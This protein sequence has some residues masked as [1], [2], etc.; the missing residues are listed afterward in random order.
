M[1][2]LMLGW[3]LPPHNSGGL[4]VACLNLA[5]A[6]SRQGVD[7]DFV[8]P[9][10]ADHPGIDFMRVLAATKLS[11]IY[12][13]GGGAYESLKL[14]EKIIPAEAQSDQKIS[15]REVQKDYCHFV[16]EYLM[17]FKPD[18]V[19]AHDWLT[20][21]AGMLARKNFGIP[22]P[23]HRIRSRWHAPWQPSDS[24]NRATGPPDGRQNHRRF[25]SD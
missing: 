21:E 17:E 6:L 1:K 19:H 15:I 2:I 23:R 5:R 7:I 16:E 11:P 12:R 8:V 18:L 25:R 3:E 4:G 9:Y 14:F 13:Y 22:C 10:E 20:Y 24:R